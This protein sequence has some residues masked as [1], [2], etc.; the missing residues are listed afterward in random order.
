MEDTNQ[1]DGPDP[2]KISLLSGLAAAVTVLWCYG[3][4]YWM[5]V[6]DA[7]CSILMCI[8]WNKRFFHQVIASSQFLGALFTT[9]LIATF[10]D[11]NFNFGAYMVAMAVFH[12]SEFHMTALYNRNTLSFDSF[13]LNH[14]QEYGIAA[15]V[16][17]VEYIVEYF[18]YP[19]MK[20]FSVVS[21][22][23]LVLVISGEA[24][25]KAAMVTA[26]SNFT[27]VVAHRKRHNHELVTTGVYSWARHPSYVGWFYWSVGT[28]L[29]L[30]NPACLVGYSIASWRFFKERIYYEEK[31]LLEFFGQQYKDYK[32]TVSSG[33]FGISG[34]P[35]IE[36]IEHTSMSNK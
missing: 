28:Q 4:Y 33:I 30:C 19:N 1:P 21:F 7:L 18:I 31:M 6:I 5:L 25:R 8:Y 36:R 27:H 29:L 34:F 24:M 11:I 10:S 17:W 20:A 9:G 3:G 14:S 15:V 26:G 2:I 23:G 16:S 12:Y 22:V 13:L 35:I 32:R